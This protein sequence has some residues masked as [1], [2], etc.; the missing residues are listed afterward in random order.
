MSTQQTFRDLVEGKKL[1][2]KDIVTILSDEDAWGDMG[3][4][5]KIVK[6]QLRIVDT[7]FYGG[8]KAM[9]FLKK[10]WTTKGGAYYDFFKSEHNIE[11]KIES[12]FEQPKAERAFQKITKDGIVGILITIK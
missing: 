10:E 8:D 9:A 5:I 12:E 7:Y 2:L 4:Y 6:G 1:K 11:F 3:D